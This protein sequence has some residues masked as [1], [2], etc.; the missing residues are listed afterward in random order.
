MGDSWGTYYKENPRVIAGSV[1]QVLFGLHRHL[2]V[3]LETSD[4]EMTAQLHPKTFQDAVKL[5]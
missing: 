3:V 1:Q 2:Q 5:S 4:S